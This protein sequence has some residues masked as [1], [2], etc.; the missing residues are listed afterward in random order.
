MNG[1][2]FIVLSR[3]LHLLW[4]QESLLLAPQKFTPRSLHH[5][6]TML[7]S[8]NFADKMITTQLIRSASRAVETERRRASMQMSTKPS[9]N[10]LLTNRL[11][12]DGE[13]G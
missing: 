1:I 7:H 12:S 3:N 2:L 11:I 10:D 8:E 6:H 5:M 9:A 13:T 4:V